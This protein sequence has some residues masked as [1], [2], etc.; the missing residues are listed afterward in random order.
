MNCAQ[1]TDTA[2]VAYCRTCG[3]ALCESCKRDVQGTIFCDPCLAARVHGG[4]NS[5]FGAAPGGYGTAAV[6]IRATAEFPKMRA[7]DWRC[8][9]IHSGRGRVL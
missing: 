2:A 5:S 7:P 4:A 8:S 1:H 6:A 9:W 3:K